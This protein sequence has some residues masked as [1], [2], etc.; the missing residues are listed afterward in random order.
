[1]WAKSRP[2]SKWFSVKTW[3]ESHNSGRPCARV[4]PTI[5]VP[6]RQALR[7]E[8]AMV[9]AEAAAARAEQVTTGRHGPAQG[10]TVQVHILWP[11]RRA[12]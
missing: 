6:A 2:L 5:F 8:S 4:Q 3:A 10:R 1:L 7:T 12:T 11:E 9:L